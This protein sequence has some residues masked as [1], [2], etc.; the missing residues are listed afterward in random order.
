MDL[1]YNDLPQK[2]LLRPDEVADFL[3][4]SRQSVHRLYESGEIEGIK[5]G[6]PLRL[7]RESVIM[8]MKKKNTEPC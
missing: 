4:L 1:S 5:T 3:R 8:Y 7:F 6:K 2:T